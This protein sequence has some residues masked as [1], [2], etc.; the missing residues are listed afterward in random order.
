M[1]KLKKLKICNWSLILLTLAIL[2]SGIYMEATDSSGLSAVWIHISLGTLFFIFA[3]YHIYLHFGKSNWF[4]KFHKL[5]NQFTRV[6]W[7][8]SLA[9][10]VSG[11]IAYIH[12]IIAFSHSPIGGVHGKIGFLMVALLAGHI[13]KRIKFFKQGIVR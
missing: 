10:L 2:I 3:A 13:Y 12:W 1:K 6:L 7:W 9:A 4:T 8:V 5:K 11:I